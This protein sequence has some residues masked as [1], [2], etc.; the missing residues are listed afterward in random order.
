MVTDRLKSLDVHKVQQIIKWTVY[1]LLIINWGFYVYEDWTRAAFTLNENSTWF[2]I[3]T[4]YAT[5]LDQLAW[6]TLLFMFELETYVLEDT[7]WK[8]SLAMSAAR[9]VCIALIA[10][11]LVAYTQTVINYSKIQPVE[12]ATSFCDV[13]DA[14]VSYVYNLAYTEVTPENCASLPETDV[15][16]WAGEIKDQVVATPASLQLELNLAWADEIEAIVWLLI[17]A[18]IEIVVRMQDRGIAGGRVITNLNRL[19]IGLYAILLTI[20]VYW[21]SLGHWVYLW[22]EILWIGGFAAI[23]MNLSQW[24]DEITDETAAEQL[25]E[26]SHA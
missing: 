4:A 5:T 25:Q 22:D 16:L 2:D 11:T 3:T 13:A 21:A 10:H 7:N 24:R 14:E 9:I 18:A 12:N 6:F 1:S 20:G 17:L 26:A 23:E 15:V 8:T 19:K